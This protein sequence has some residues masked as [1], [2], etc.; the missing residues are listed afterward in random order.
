MERAFSAE[1]KQ[2][3]LDM[4]KQIGDEV[5]QKGTVDHTPVYPREVVKPGDRLRVRPGD[6]LVLAGLVFS[7]NSGTGQQ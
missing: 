5:Q 4:V 1:A 6:S 7:N 3:A 2:R